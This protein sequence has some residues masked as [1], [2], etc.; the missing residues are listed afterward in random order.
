MIAFVGSGEVVAAQQQYGVYFTTT[1]GQPPGQA[2]KGFVVLRVEWGSGTY[3]A[4]NHIHPVPA[5][6]GYHLLKESFLLLVN[7][8]E[9]RPPFFMGQTEIVFEGKMQV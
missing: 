2:F 4:D 1:C 6:S 8:P 9:I 5:I 3:H 7:P